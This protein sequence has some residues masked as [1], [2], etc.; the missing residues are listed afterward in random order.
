MRPGARERGAKAVVAY[1][2]A[3]ALQ[4]VRKPLMIIR[5]RDDLWEATLRARPLVGDAVWVEYPDYSHGLFE[6]AA[7][8]LAVLIDEF[9]TT[10][11]T[12]RE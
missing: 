3:S 1:D 7:A 8:E 9:L 4:E 11:G 6:V 12:D 2:L 10:P 5:P